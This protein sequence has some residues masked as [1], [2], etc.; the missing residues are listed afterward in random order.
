VVEGEFEQ[1]SRRQ[2]GAGTAKRDARRRQL[3][4]ILDRTARRCRRRP[5]AN[6]QNTFL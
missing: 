3:P 4:Q 6:F 2:A 5:S 1:R